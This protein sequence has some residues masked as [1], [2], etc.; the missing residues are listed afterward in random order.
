MRRGAPEHPEPRAP[1]LSR[2]APD[3]CCQAW[4]PPEK[5]PGGAL[6]FSSNTWTPPSPSIGRPEPRNFV[7]SCPAQRPGLAGPSR[8]CLGSAWENRVCRALAHAAEGANGRSETSAIP[9]CRGSG[10]SGT[11]GHKQFSRGAASAEPAW[12]AASCGS[13]QRD[14]RLRGWDLGV[15]FSDGRSRLQRPRKPPRL[16][17]IPKA[18]LDLRKEMLARCRVGVD[19]QGAMKPRL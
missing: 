16:S 6:R 19:S 1:R 13:L 15:A 2:T 5:S 3:C 4:F 7:N 11:P 10:P 12:G 14:R 17:G 9:Q 18:R 8:L